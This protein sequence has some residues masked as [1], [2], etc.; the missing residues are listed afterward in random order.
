MNNNDIFGRLVKKQGTELD[1]SD[2]QITS[3]SIQENIEKISP[4][5]LLLEKL[6]I[7]ENR[8]ISLPPEIGQFVSLRIL[9]ISNNKLQCLPVQI[10]ELTNLETLNLSNNG[11]NSLP[12]E[13][14]RLKKLENLYLE[15]NPLSLMPPEILKQGTR[16]ILLYLQEQLRT[17]GV[18]QW[19][20]KL[21]VVGEGGVGKTQLL[22]RLRGEAFNPQETTTHGIEIQALELEHPTEV[23]VSDSKEKLSENSSTTHV[24]S[25]IASIFLKEQ[26]D[27]T[28][29]RQR[30]KKVTMR[31]NTWDFGGQEIYHATHQF[32]LT[33]RSLF[34]LIWNARTD[35][36]QANLYY[37]LKIIRANAPESP[38]LLVATHIDER[39][40]DIPLNDIRR[41]FP[42][43]IGQCKVSNKDGTGIDQL[44]QKI[45]EVAA[46]LPLM[47]EIW[48]T[49][50][51]NFANWVR[52][53]S[54]KYIKPQQ[55]WD[56]MRNYGVASEGQRVLAQ[57]LHELGEIL[58]FQ[59]NDE[60]KHIIILKPQWVTEYISK[61]LEAQEV[62]ERKGIFTRTC[63]ERI[64][65]DLDSNI[66]DHFLCLMERFDLSYRTLENKDTS[67]IVERLPFE[68]P[69]YE[70]HWL[71][72]KREPNCQEISMKFELS[73]ILP[74]IPTWFIAREHRFTLN[75]HWRTGVLF[76]DVRHKPKHLGL[77][78]MVRDEK[79]NAEYLHLIVRGPMPHSFFDVLKEGLEF[80][81]RR[82][83]GLH[84][85]RSLPCPDPKRR[86]C[87]HYFDYAQLAKRLEHKPSKPLVECPECL[88]DDIS[89]T[90]LLFGLHYTTESAVIDSLDRLIATSRSTE[91]GFNELQE[92]VQ[93][94]FIRQFR[95]EQQ[96]LET[97]CPNVFVLR[98]RE[99][100]SWNNSFAE[101][102]NLQLYCQKPG[103][104][105]PTKEGGLYAID[106]PHQLLRAT[107]PYLKGLVKRLKYT[108]P[109]VGPWV[110]IPAQEYEE[111]IRLDQQLMNDLSTK[112]DE[113]LRDI[114]LNSME[115]ITSNSNSQQFHGAALRA[116][117]KFL[118]KADPDQYW[119]NLQQVETPEGDYLWLCEDHAREYN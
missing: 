24:L 52:T 48:P 101:Q 107:A 116:L 3:E 104:W 5:Y 81:L 79:R 70:S 59:Y 62:I 85:T 115:S 97:Q 58:F 20:S 110:G 56:S 102:I 86:D 47:G 99:R 34:L 40:P 65:R 119:G 31:L 57:W 108:T 44:K 27:N 71:K 98:P 84:I 94:Q 39:D 72:I 69:E 17:T 11:L 42:K 93:R 82:Y 7:G 30:Q 2:L 87:S 105:H 74:G 92:L 45:A 67:L 38:I 75:L 18:P 61:A 113:N 8:L 68:I 28:H 73:E 118:E 90:Q 46:Q 76:G 21:L 83:P 91:N 114:N 33:N 54:D 95:Q 4:Y 106:E 77:V 9:N 88:K 109:I 112:L 103:C 78:K 13:I 6:D 53:I 117:R 63:M 29:N 100:Q 10:G 49:S 80:T 111:L 55:F 35:F 37:W 23:V 32:F 96:Y 22:R 14:S 19:V 50:W 64:W 66:Q 36:K 60:L 51:L 89:V 16:A 43:I 15:G 12:P 1:I 25:K 26:E 41:Q